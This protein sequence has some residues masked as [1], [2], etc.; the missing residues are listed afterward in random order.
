MCSVMFL[1]LET[2]RGK[3]K[4]GECQD[5]SGTDYVCLACDQ[6]G[7]TEKAISFKVRTRVSS[8]ECIGWIGLLGETLS[9]PILCDAKN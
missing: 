2:R 9:I 5:H 1:W 6:R 4:F 8:V 7:D 3:S